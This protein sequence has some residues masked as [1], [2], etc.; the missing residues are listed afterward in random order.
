MNSSIENILKKLRRSFYKPK[1]NFAFKVIK[2][3]I[4]YP[5]EGFSIQAFI[6]FANRFSF[7]LDTEEI[8]LLFSNIQENN[9]VTKS[10]F[11]ANVVV[12]I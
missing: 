5:E 12:S 1:R 8:Q 7:G 11:L 6:D 3:I 4:N 2:E 10:A 9:V